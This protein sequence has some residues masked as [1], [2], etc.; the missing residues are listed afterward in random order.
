MTAGASRHWADIS[1]STSVAGIR[2]L[3]VVYRWLGYWPYRLC[4]WPVVVCHWLFNHFGR[5]SSMEYLGRL[6]AET[7]AL[8]HQPGRLDSLRHFLAYADTLLDKILALGGRYPLARVQLHHEV[9][10][11]DRRLGRGGLFLTTHMGCLELSQV[12]A[13]QIPDFR[14]TIL[15]HTRHVQQFNQL[16]Q[17]LDPLAAVDLLQVTEVGPGTA[18]ALREKVAAGGYVAIVGDRVPVGGGRSMEVDFLGRKAHFPIGPYVL[19]AALQCPIY[20]MVCLHSGTGYRIDFERFS[21][22][23]TLPRGRREA[24]LAEQVRR[25]AGWLERQV[26]QSPLD[27][28]NFFPFWDQGRAIG[29]GSTVGAAGHD[30]RE[31]ASEALSCCPTRQSRLRPAASI[32]DTRQ[33]CQE[34][35]VDD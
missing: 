4:V 10:L 11:A 29:T 15:V 18:V 28:F 34:S 24:L 9:V 17:R 27:W 12:L 7:G 23:L 5:A 16:L 26:R 3:C 21:E 14:L 2:F 22:Q 32:M 13:D 20:T 30:S 6:Q 8:G 25:Y 35:H 19:A 31:G 1:E 33:S